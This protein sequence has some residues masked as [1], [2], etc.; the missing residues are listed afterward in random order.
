MRRAGFSLLEMLIAVALMAAG[1]ALAFG[2]LQG[3]LRSAASA[4]RIAQHNDRV[5]TAQGFLRRQL[6]AALPQAIDPAAG[7]EDLRLLRLSQD[8]VELVGEMPGYLGR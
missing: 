8:R 6:A 7:F 1:L 5:R 4:E 2:I 3:S